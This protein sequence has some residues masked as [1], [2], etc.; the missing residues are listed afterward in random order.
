MSFSPVRNCKQPRTQSQ[1]LNLHPNPPSTQTLQIKLHDHNR[2]FSRLGAGW[3]LVGRQSKKNNPSA[4]WPRKRLIFMQHAQLEPS[5]WVE[6]ITVCENEPCPIKTCWSDAIVSGITPT[7]LCVRA[8]ACVRVR[9][10]VCV[11]A[12][13]RLCVC[14]FVC[15]CVCFFLLLFFVFFFS[16]LHQVG[17]VLKLHSTAICL[18]VWFGA[19]VLRHNTSLSLSLSLSARACVH[20]CPC[21]RACVCVPFLPCL[22]CRL[23]FSARFHSFQ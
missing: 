7:L 23:A 6:V 4:L 5:S 18:V 2:K 20:A 3:R 15:V 9:A 1:C 12:R 17:C 10:C 13:A 14:V 8:C 11:R 22:F 16:S 19:G 21:V